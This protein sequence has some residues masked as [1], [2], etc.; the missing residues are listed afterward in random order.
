M[1]DVLV[2]LVVQQVV[3]AAVVE[4]LHFLSDFSAQYRNCEMAVLASMPA[5]N[6]TKDRTYSYP[7][8]LQ[9]E[10][11]TSVHTFSSLPRRALFVEL[12]NCNAVSSIYHVYRGLCALLN[13]CLHNLC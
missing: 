6:N 10:V 4:L 13:K 8:E 11:W 2:V 1:F 7:S 9:S 12:S 5:I 3:V